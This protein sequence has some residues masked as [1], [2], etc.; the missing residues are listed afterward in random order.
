[1]EVQK[2]RNIAFVGHGN[3]GKTSLAEAISYHG[4]LTTRKGTIEE[5]NTICDSDQDEKERK[6]SIELCLLSCPWRDHKI[7]L[8][9]TPG[10]A[11]FFGEVVSALRVVDSAAL[12]ISASS[13]VEVG[14][15]RG[16]DWIQQYNLPTIIFI[17]KMDTENAN[18][19]NSLEAIRE[20]LSSQ[21]TPLQLPIGEGS[22]FKGVV[23]LL[24]NKAYVA[25]QGAM[26][27][28]KVPDELQDE[29]NDLRDKLIETIAECDD[30]LLEKYL[31]GEKLSDQEIEK[32]IRK[33][34]RQRSLIP[35]LCGSVLNDVGIGLL[36]DNVIDICPSPAEGGPAK[37]IN[38]KSNEPE[39][40]NPD[41]KEDFSALV[42]KTKIEPHVGQ[43]N[44][45]RVYSGKVSSGEEVYNSVSQNREKI[46]QL[47]I[48]QG[49]EQKKV[50]E[51][52]V[53]DMGAVLKLKS[54]STGDTLGKLSRPITLE[55][56]KFP[57]PIISLAL[58]PTSKKDQEKLSTA[59]GQLVSEDPTLKWHMEHEFGEAIISGMGE[60]HLEILIGRLKRRFG[61]E[62][63]LGKPRI[64]YR[65]TIRAK[66]KTQ[67][68]YKKQ[69][70]GRG[71]YGD[72]WI[73]IEPL[74]LG[75]GFEFAN[76]IFGGAIP[77]KYIPSVEKGIK[78]SLAKGVLAGYPVV[79]VKVTLCDGSYHDV[80]SS[81]MAF[82]IAG[83]MAFKKAVQDAKPVLL[84]PIVSVEVIAPEKYMGDLNG[85]LNSRR[86]RIM[87]IEAKGKNQIIKAQVP[88]AEMYKYATSLKSITHGQ[89]TYGMKFSHYEEV[90]SRTAQ[91]IITQAT[92]KEE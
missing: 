55:G 17:N 6:I 24:K 57:E 68:K 69:T 8:I 12:V 5:G 50:S 23:D 1:M 91:G 28:S 15:E 42:F 51:V 35:V 89:G 83:S 34:V 9:D 40:R 4:K 61:V 73:A 14:T 22:S 76:E 26:E 20:T 33:A 31:E 85:D 60:L 79:D 86:G 39:E 53:G 13:G 46:V 88:L 84:E 63:E 75:K 80:D 2:I 10:Y 3:C 29:V 21:A 78:E 74:E 70:G 66:V 56:F 62:V 18:F 81:D 64:P 41:E 27:E 36:L 44:F 43:M 48:P 37:G 59:L 58:K 77:A 16:W 47:I 49:K 30:G 82:K 90:P 71:Q 7:N 38:P 11:D 25:S 72:C 92:K 54:T 32:G 52:E 87:G 45:F 67:G 19:R 65:E